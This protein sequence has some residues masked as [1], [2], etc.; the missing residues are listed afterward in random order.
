MNTS[1]KTLAIISALAL[2]SILFTACSDSSPSASKSDPIESSSLKD[3]TSQ[4]TIWGVAATGFAAPSK[5]VYLKNEAGVRFCDGK[6]NAAGEYQCL[7]SKSQ[8]KWPFEVVVELDEADIIAIIPEPIDGSH[9]I[10]AHVNQVTST[11]AKMA[12]KKMTRQE[13]TRT[14]LDS[15]N[16]QH[17][18][19]L[20]GNGV[21]ADAFVR[22]PN[23]KAAQKANANVKPC[24]EDVVL[25]TMGGLAELHQK[26]IQEFVFDAT[27]NRAFLIE[28]DIEFL[29]YLGAYLTDYGFTD[30]E[31]ISG[32]GNFFTKKGGS[33][34]SLA[35]NIEFYKYNYENKL[36]E[37][38]TCY[39]NSFAKEFAKERTYLENLSY[40]SRG[41]TLAMQACDVHRKIIEK[42]AS[43][44]ISDSTCQGK[45]DLAFPV[46][47]RGD[48]LKK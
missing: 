24:F 48:Q 10:V 45:H 36:G 18:W 5:K 21:D 4:D 26:Q 19:Q 6:T 3:S 13:M 12:D 27:S 46:L 38:P 35:A 2:S 22:A 29:S 20:F 14:R 33:I 9:K 39:G 17:S 16:E 23:F 28:S 34:D 42:L 7:Y 31:T 41:D 8:A 40:E 32:V 44:L 47:P 37:T 11:F 1:T 43:D 25:H 15:L 30:K